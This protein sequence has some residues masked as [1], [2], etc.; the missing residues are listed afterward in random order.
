MPAHAKTIKKHHHHHR[1]VSSVKNVKHRLITVAHSMLQ[2]RVTHRMMNYF[3]E[4][5]VEIYIYDE[6]DRREGKI[7]LN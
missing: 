2:Q 4:P 6:S 7:S 5:A 1:R 3:Q